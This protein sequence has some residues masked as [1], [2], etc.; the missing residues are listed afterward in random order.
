MTKAP[1]KDCPD[2]VIGCHSNCERYK[3]FRR[4]LEAE[5]AHTRPSDAD[6][7]LVGRIKRISKALG[8]KRK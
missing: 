4:A 3:A 1:C 8:R 7:Y 2:R 5:K 6:I